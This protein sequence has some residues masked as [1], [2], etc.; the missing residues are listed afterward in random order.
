MIEILLVI[1]LKNLLKKSRP[2]P[3]YVDSPMYLNTPL[4]D[5]NRQSRK[6]YAII[7]TP[8]VKSTIGQEIIECKTH[9][10][11]TWLRLMNISWCEMISYIHIPPYLKM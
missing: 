1:Y 3:L 8:I 10:K 7:C 2:P 6:I 11:M 9:D 5:K 4:G